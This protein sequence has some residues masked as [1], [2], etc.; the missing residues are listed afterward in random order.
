MIKTVLFDLDGTLL[1][2]DQNS[3]LKDYFGRLIKKM[4][5]HGYDSELLQKSIWACTKAMIQNDGTRSNEEA[6]WHRFTE[7]YEKDVRSDEP[8]FLDFYKNEF[9]EVRHSCGFDQRA[10]D[11]IHELKERG[12][13]LVLATNPLFPAVATQSR[14]RWAG[15]TPEDFEWITTYE[16]AS[17]CKPNLDYYRE[18]LV[19][20]NLQPEECLMVGNDVEEDMIAES[21][22]MRVFLLTDC[23]INPNKMDIHVFSH[24]GFPELLNYLRSVCLCCF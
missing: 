11:V 8:V 24:G 9:Q 20:L 18:I 21:L 23:I 13:R 2:M 12:I 3:F 1:P 17:F 6:F 14:I 22:G 15:L 7:I 4:V 16:N 10:V 19:K 5:P